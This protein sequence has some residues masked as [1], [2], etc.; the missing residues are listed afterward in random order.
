MNPIVV[1][2][3][4]RESYRLAWETFEGNRFLDLRIYYDDGSGELKPSRKGLSIKPE[5]IPAIIE[6]LGIAKDGAQ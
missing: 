2:K 3:N 6:A 4:S 5:V 1:R